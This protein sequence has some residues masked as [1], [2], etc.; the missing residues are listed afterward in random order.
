MNIND[1]P[2]PMFRPYGVPFFKFNL[3]PDLSTINDLIDKVDFLNKKDRFENKSNM[4]GFHSADIGEDDWN[5]FEAGQ[6]F[7]KSV[8]KTL[9]IVMRLLRNS[10][11]P[12][13]ALELT[14]SWFMKNAANS[15]NWNIPHTHPSSYLSGAFYLS[16]QPKTEGT[17]E[18]IA[19]VENSSISS[20][21][22]DRE[23]LKLVEYY[24]VKGELILFPSSTIHMV[25]PHTADYD[26][27]MISFNTKLKDDDCDMRGAKKL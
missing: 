27:I 9:L 4:G 1:S 20:I 2:G 15:S 21:Q 13:D 7:V 14:N 6:W 12:V 11:N 16:G 19:I 26:R 17:G 22:K 24:P 3:N 10:R 5:T 25:T 23:D 8:N 18:F